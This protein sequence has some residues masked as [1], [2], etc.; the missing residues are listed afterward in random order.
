MPGCTPEAESRVQG[1]ALAKRRRLRQGHAETGHASVVPCYVPNSPF[2]LCGPQAQ[3]DQVVQEGVQPSR[4]AQLRRGRMSGE[5][6]LHVRIKAAGGQKVAS[7]AAFAASLLGLAHLVLYVFTPGSRHRAAGLPWKRASVRCQAFVAGSV[8]A[9]RCRSPR[10]LVWISVS[11]PAGTE[12]AKPNATDRQTERVEC[13]A[14]EEF[15]GL[16][17]ASS[18]VTG[19]CEAAAQVNCS[20]NYRSLCAQRSSEAWKRRSWIDWTHR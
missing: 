14:A 16:L 11:S 1:C 13:P 17:L 2:S 18:A 3:V 15:P 19:A 12:A 6:R 7:V 8:S 5:H 4:L 9:S 10:S 20:R